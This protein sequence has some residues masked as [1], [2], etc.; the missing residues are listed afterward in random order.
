MMLR[1]TSLLLIAIG[2]QAADVLV[3]SFFRGNGEDGLYLATSRDGLRWT[4]L[5]G[6]K[7]VVAPSVGESKLMRDPSITRGPDG[8]FHMVWTTSW[9]GRSFGYASSRDLRT[10]TP[11]VAV[12]PF[13]N[14]DVVNV[15]APE[16]F[17]DA[18]SRDFVIVWASTI[19][20][21]FP[22]TLAAGHKGYNH[23]LYFT[24]TRDFK[25]FTPA[26][27]FYDPGFQVIDGAVFAFDGG[28]AMVAKNETLTP[29]AKYLFLTFAKSIEGPWSAPS[30]S[31]SGE[32]WAEGPTPVKIG[33]YWYV[34]FDRY[35]DKRYGVIRSRDL[36]KWEDLS[37]RLQ[38]PAGVRHGTVFH[39]PEHMIEALQK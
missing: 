9:Q 20:G 13:A 11:Q 27:V 33:E 1:C 17:Y 5:N 36:K 15:W 19:G 24:R 6:D 2:L 7:A 16:I 28:Y 26:R 37:E 29:P 8:T 21:R 32:G 34:Y 10:W 31:I 30:G 39:A 22:E 12:T 35:R 4:P 23:R 38:L 18:R 25:T 3:F 14:E